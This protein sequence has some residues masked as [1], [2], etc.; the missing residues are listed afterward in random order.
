MPNLEF[1]PPPPPADRQAAAAATRAYLAA[2]ADR[3][4]EDVRAGLAADAETAAI[5]RTLADHP[6]GAAYLAAADDHAE[7]RARAT[8]R[9]APTAAMTLDHA[10]QAAAELPAEHARQIA[11]AAAAV[12]T[13][14]ERLAAAEADDSARAAA[15][16]DAAERMHSLW[17][18][19]R[20]VIDANRPPAPADRLAP[21]AA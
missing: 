11:A 14:R 17:P 6:D 9:N 2:E 5:R 20:A 7:A 4:A 16:A 10:R 18:A 8:R 12:N 3:I 21:P 1:L 15:V 13:A 19:A